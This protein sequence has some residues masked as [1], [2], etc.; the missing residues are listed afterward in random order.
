MNA[1][2]IKKLV[3]DIVAKSQ[4]LSIAHTFEKNT[5]V[6]Y[7]C[8]FTH[9]VTEYEEML[10][11]AR[12][13]GAVAQETPTGIVFGIPPLQTVSGDLRLL[14]IRKPDSKRPERGDADFTISDYSAFKKKFLGKPGFSIVE[15]A[16]YEMIELIDSSYDVIVYYSHPTLAEILK[17][18]K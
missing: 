11:V 1:A 6:N 2:E 14:K 7:A 10:K 17:L 15:R 13:F 9:S 16:D 12:E 4:Q 3:Q 8:I 18:N 5:P